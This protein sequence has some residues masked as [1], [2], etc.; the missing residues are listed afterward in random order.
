MWPCSLTAVPELAMQSTM[1]EML[2]LSD[3]KK[4][5]PSP[6]DECHHD[7]GNT[8]PAK[9]KRTTFLRTRHF[10]MFNCPALYMN[11]YNSKQITLHLHDGTEVKFHIFYTPTNNGDTGLAAS[12][13][14]FNH[15]EYNPL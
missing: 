12:I 5:C 8:M 9:H 14:C 3:K 1:I 4:Q 7:Q 13:S 11:L 15:M 10:T 6:Q 2:P